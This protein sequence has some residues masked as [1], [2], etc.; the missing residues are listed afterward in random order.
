MNTKDDEK[1]FE[2][3]MSM[4]DLICKWSKDP[5]SQVAAVAINQKRQ[6]LSMG[7]NGFPRRIKDDESRYAVREVKYKYVLHAEQNLISNAV[8]NGISLDHSVVL[9]SGIPP[10]ERCALE[11]IQADISTVVVKGSDITKLQIEKRDTWIDGFRLACEL[12]EEAKVKIVI[13]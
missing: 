1:W 10:C 9:V 4:A 5:S 13:L 12:F 2:R 6:L 8:S 7:Y 11:L 3:F